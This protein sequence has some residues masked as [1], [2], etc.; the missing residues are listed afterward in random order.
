MAMRVTHTKIYSHRTTPA[1]GSKIITMSEPHENT[2]SGQYDPPLT[3]LCL[4]VFLSVIP[5]TLLVP[6]LKPLVLDRFPVG[7]F[8]AHAFL[9]A[10]M[11]SAILAAPAM[12]WIVDRIGKRQPIVVGAFVLDAFLLMSLNWAPN[13]WALM[14][15]RFMEGIT[16]IAALTGVMG[17]ALTLA[18]RNPERAGGIM[19]AIGGAIIFAVATGAG[20]G[21]ALSRDGILRPIIAAML[22]GLL[23]ALISGW[24]L[25]HDRRVKPQEGGHNL[26]TLMR[27]FRKEKAL[28]APCLFTFADRLLVGIIIS[29]FNLYLVQTLGWSPKQFGFLMST[30]L[31][32][33]ALLCYPFGKLCRSWSKSGLLVGASLAYALFV[34]SLAWLDPGWLF[35]SMLVLGVISAL[36]FSPSLAMVA[37]LTGAESRSTA[38]GAFNSAGSLGFFAGPLLGGAVVHFM[39]AS[40]SPLIE[41]YKMAFIAG[42]AISILCTLISIPFLIQLVREGRTT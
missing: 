28:L 14:A 6:I 24:V 23:G 18:H 21:G 7:P 27:V 33:F 2:E 38:M 34:A 30:L 22:I 41:S 4:L 25:R 17:A 32:P 36:N 9:S 8:A 37:D 11:V 26:A 20:L 1:P 29:S 35:P 13:Y 39:L 42:G 16:H 12:G 10:N 15:V 5:V 3:V 31:L 40:G 19:G